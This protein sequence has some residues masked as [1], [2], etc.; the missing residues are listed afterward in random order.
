M[1]PRALIALAMLLLPLS[2]QAMS[3]AQALAELSGANGPERFAVVREGLYRGGQPTPHHLA[4]LRA[5]GVDTILNLRLG[6]GS[7]H[8]EAAEA[9]RL[10]MRAVDVSFSGLFRVDAPFLMRAIE[11]IREGGR[12]YVHCRL[13]RDRTSLVIALERVILEGWK[14]DAAW[15]HDAVAFGYRPDLF[16]RTIAQ[17]FRAAVRTLGR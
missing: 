7:A 8:A 15:Q 4:L 3:P 13:G 1:S 5:V 16:H 2:A 11:A 17:S 9:A 14:A 10:G 12:V 6:Y